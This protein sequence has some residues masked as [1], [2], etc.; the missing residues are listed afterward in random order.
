MP[1]VIP[2]K[3]GSPV[4]KWIPAF[5]RN[6]DLSEQATQAQICFL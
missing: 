4:K 3:I 6:D 1:V 5:A 2:M